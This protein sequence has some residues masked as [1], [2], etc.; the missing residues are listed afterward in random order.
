M[1]CPRLWSVTYSFTQ[2]IHVSHSSMKMGKKFK[3]IWIWISLILFMATSKLSSI[4]KLLTYIAF[5]MN[6]CH[7]NRW[8]CMFLIKSTLGLNLFID[9]IC[10]MLLYMKIYYYLTRWFI[11]SLTTLV[12]HV[13]LVYDKTSKKECKFLKIIV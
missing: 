2:M 13:T 12:S 8:R 9:K 1:T 10:F 7:G 4:L 6:F 11:P 5:L 3:I